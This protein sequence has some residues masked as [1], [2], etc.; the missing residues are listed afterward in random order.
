[1]HASASTATLTSLILFLSSQAIAAPTFGV[2]KSNACH[3]LPAVPDFS[4][5]CPGSDLKMREALYK[6]DLVLQPSVGL[7]KR[8]CPS[9][10]QGSYKEAW[11]SSCS[12]SLLK[13]QSDATVGAYGAS[14]GAGG[15]GGSG[16]SDGNPAPLNCP[17]MTDPNSSGAIKPCTRRRDEMIERRGGGYD[18]ATAGS[19]FNI[20]GGGST[21]PPSARPLTC[22][23]W[24]DTRPI[25]PWIHMCT[26][27]ARRAM[28]A[29]AAGREEK[30]PL[31]IFNS[32]DLLVGPNSGGVAPAG[33]D[34]SQVWTAGKDKRQAAGM[35]AAAVA[36]AS[37]P[38]QSSNGK[39]QA[40]GMW[41]AA[42][43]TASRPQQSPNRKRQAAGMEAA[44]DVA[45]SQPQSGSSNAKRQ[46]EES[47]AA[48]IVAA[49]QSQ[50]GFSNGKRQAAGMD[51]AAVVA[52][53]QPQPASSNG[54][55]QAAGMWAAAIATISQPQQSPNGKRQAAGMDAAAVVAASEPQ[56]GSKQRRADTKRQGGG[57]LASGDAGGL[58]QGS[59]DE[60]TNWNPKAMRDSHLAG[61]F[62]SD[63]APST[64]TLKPAQQPEANPTARDISLGGAEEAYKMMLDAG[65]S[66]AERCRNWT[67]EEPVEEWV[68]S[69][70][71]GVSKARRDVGT[72]MIPVSSSYM[73]MLLNGWSNDTACEV[74][75]K[76]ISLSDFI[77]LCQD[78]LTDIPTNQTSEIPILSSYSDM[79][80]D[81]WSEDPQCAYWNYTQS[82]SAFVRACQPFSQPSR[83]ASHYADAIALDNGDVQGC[84]STALAK[85][86][87]EDSQTQ[88]IWR[89]MCNDM[90]SGNFVR[91][92]DDVEGQAESGSL[93]DVCANPVVREDEAYRDWWLAHCTKRD[94]MPLSGAEGKAKRE[95]IIAWSETPDAK[96]A[97]QHD[98]Y[99]QI[100]EDDLPEDLGD[101]DADFWILECLYQRFKLD[102]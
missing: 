52:A 96:L 99:R 86:Q 21:P 75:D 40:A 65:W 33:G 42:I 95:S 23:E 98:K 13:R 35:E 62:S 8:L 43:A 64:Q 47:D 90:A 7:C 87:D 1:M 22:T 39:R 28:E 50:D 72:V 91:R 49:S 26:A 85:F 55:R 30:L 4:W 82:L 81:G 100:C 38:Q 102:E 83:R 48:A 20:Y 77:L 74:W 27:A 54:K 84:S 101:E 9:E 41:A 10:K 66:P 44:A 16:G 61:R 11:L 14:G 67:R 97:T 3:D 25:S 2:G 51:A 12:Q 78:D 18:T 5:A 68:Q 6:L 15:G 89:V 45:A 80:G 32:P 53:S 88:R 79:L 71:G 31:T 24:N 57:S 70:S 60:G 59:P 92:Q 37:Q 69:C 63:S 56:T 17:E 73:D 29:R 46:T 58:T 76:T 36:A 93:A 34:S 19:F 94:V